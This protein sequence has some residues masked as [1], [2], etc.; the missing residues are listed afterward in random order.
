MLLSTELAADEFH[1]H[2]DACHLFR[3]FVTLVL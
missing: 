3:L 2:D 1:E